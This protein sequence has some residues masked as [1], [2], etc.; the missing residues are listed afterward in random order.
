MRLSEEVM[1]EIKLL[2]N[3]PRKWFGIKYPTL[4]KDVCGVSVADIHSDPCVALFESSRIAD[5]TI[6][7][8][9]KCNRR[10]WQLRLLMECVYKHYGTEGVKACCPILSNE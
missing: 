10:K 4:L 2:I 6:S 8:F 7:S 3:F 9:R 5:G 1:K